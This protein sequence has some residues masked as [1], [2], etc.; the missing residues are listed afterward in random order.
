MRRGKSKD[1]L[2]VVVFFPRVNHGELTTHLE[3][4]VSKYVHL[5]QAAQGVNKYLNT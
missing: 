2:V 5:F 4:L 3:P 1:Q